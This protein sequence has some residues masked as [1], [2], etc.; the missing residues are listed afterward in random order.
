[1][2]KLLNDAGQVELFP[3]LCPHCDQTYWYAPGQA[4][5][6]SAAG[7]LPEDCL[8]AM[9]AEGFSN[10]QGRRWWATLHAD[11]EA[12]GLRKGYEAL[13]KM[14]LEAKLSI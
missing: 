5:G 3:I 14:A 12:A 8:A 13:K 11:G 2:L 7:K 4:I 10:N 9:R 1:M 6:D